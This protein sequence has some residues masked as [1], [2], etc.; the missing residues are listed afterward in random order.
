MV[1]DLPKSHLRPATH[2]T[3]YDLAS[4]EDGDL[5]VFVELSAA[6]TGFSPAEL[7]GT[8]MAE[9]YFEALRLVVGKKI[10]AR[11]VHSGL[12][13][14][15]LLAS[16]LYGPLARNV[17]RMWYLGQWKQIPPEWL[18]LEELGEDETRGFNEFGRNTDRV[19]SSQAYQQGL[20][21]IA[22]GVNPVG[23]KQPGY[24]SW[25]WPPR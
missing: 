6:L 19:L 22:M 24:G 18:K 13:P 17:I 2:F 1:N 11:F 3:E 21:W 4:V 5:D 9:S 10:C 25:A 7:G 8:G 16:N 15:A 12:D 14:A 20:A 23:A